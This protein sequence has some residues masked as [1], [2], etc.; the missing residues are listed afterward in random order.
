M[1]NYIENSLHIKETEQ[2]LGYTHNSTEKL[3]DKG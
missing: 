2:Q 1:E 3:K